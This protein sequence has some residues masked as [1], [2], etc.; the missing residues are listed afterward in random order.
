MLCTP[1][2]WAL[3]ALTLTLLLSACNGTTSTP[4]GSSNTAPTVTLTA[5]PMTGTAPYSSVLT[6]TATDPEGDP[7]S[8][9]WTTPDGTV[10]GSA[11]FTYTMSAAGSYPVAVTVSDGKLSASQSTTLSATAPPNIPGNR[12]PA[13]SLA[14]TPSSGDAPLEV[15]FTAQGQDPDG[16]ALTYLW[17][18]GDGESA[19]NVTKVSHTYQKAGS[20]KAKVTVSDGHGGTNSATQTIKVSGKTEPEPDPVQGKGTVKIDVTPNNASWQLGT[21]SG[22][23]NDSVKLSPDT[24]TLEVTPADGSPFTPTTQS[25][26]VEADKTSKVEVRLEPIR[27]AGFEVI[28]R[29]IGTTLSQGEEINA[30]VLAGEPYYNFNGI[31]LPLTFETDA[32]PVTLT[33]LDGYQ[34][35]PEEEYGH[36]W[37]LSYRAEFADDMVG[38]SVVLH[39]T[40]SSPFN[41]KFLDYIGEGTLTLLTD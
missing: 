31:D 39:P 1:R 35:L 29:G 15:S 38:Q 19:G 10:P 23:G 36:S 27:S 24:Y 26:T 6:A 12:A 4:D 17:S 20:Y 18:F 21:E 3:S 5:S 40:S 41:I 34:L 22:T 16:D 30:E 8:Y 7:L 14:A 28:L 13:V 11:S 33:Y 25:V 37:A 2:T 32:G 9:M